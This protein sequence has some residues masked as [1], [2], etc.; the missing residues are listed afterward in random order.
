[1]NPH[2][3]SKAFAAM[4]KIIPSAFA[5]HDF[6]LQQVTGHTPET[7]FRSLKLGTSTSEMLLYHFQVKISKLRKFAISVAAT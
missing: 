3:G 1:M 2:Q 5:G 7:M 4:Q 6:L